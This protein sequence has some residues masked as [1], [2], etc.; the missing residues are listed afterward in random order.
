MIEIYSKNNCMQC[1]MVKQYLNKHGVKYIVKNI[2]D[3][4]G[5]REELKAKGFQSVPITIK[6]DIVIQGF[7][8]NKLIE[9]I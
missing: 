5:V 4:L 2:D 1:R 7:A 9:L 6:D 3:D 8:P